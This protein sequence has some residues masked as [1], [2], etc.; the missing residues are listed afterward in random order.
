[1][2]PVAMADPL[3]SCLWPIP[4]CKGC[5]GPSAERHRSQRK[6]AI[7]AD[8]VTCCGNHIVP[9]VCVF[10]YLPVNEQSGFTVH[11]CSSLSCPSGCKTISDQKRETDVVHNTRLLRPSYR[12]RFWPTQTSAVSVQAFI[13]LA[14]DVFNNQWLFYELGADVIVLQES[15][16]H[17]SWNITSYCIYT[18][19][20]LPFQKSFLGTNV[21]S[22]R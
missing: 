18:L 12:N 1:M 21:T 2:A 3:L 6:S 5:D 14:E 4:K 20:G 10:V 13:R 9:C 16:R 22:V 15:M 11:A 17:H 7:I 8:G 19:D